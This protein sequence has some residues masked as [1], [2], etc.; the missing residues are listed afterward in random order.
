MKY[1]PYICT[2]QTFKRAED[3]AQHGGFFSAIFLSDIIIA[4]PCEVVETP[5]RLTA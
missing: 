2:V 3:V 5:S 4:A 1:K